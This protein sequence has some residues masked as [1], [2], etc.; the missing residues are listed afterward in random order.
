MNLV[1]RIVAA[2]N[3]AAGLERA[4]AREILRRVETKGFR[5][6]G[7]QSSTNRRT[8][9]QSL[10][11]PDSSG[12]HADRIQLIREAR[13]LEENSAVIKSILRKYRTFAVGRLQYI[14]RTK[15]EAV[16]KQINDYV[17]RWM[18]HADLCKK[19]HF[20]TLAGLGVTSMKRDGDVGF[21]VTEVEPTEMEQALKICPIR[22]QAIEADRIGSAIGYA[23]PATGKPF[24]KLAKGE[25]DFSGVVVDSLGRPKRY[26]V[27]NRATT[28]STMVPALEVAAE[29]FIHLYDPTRLD[30]YRG[31]S[32][33]DAAIND[34]K[35]AQEI[36]ACEKISVKYLSSVSGVVKNAAGEPEG[37]VVLDDSHDDYNANAASLKAVRPGEIKYLQE[38]QDFSALNFDRPTPTFNGFLET[39]MRWTGLTVNLPFGFI[40]SWAGQGTAVRMEAAQAAREFEQTQL[41]LE[42]RFLDPIIQRVIARGIQLGHI[43]PVPD[44]DSGEWRYPARVTADVGRESKALI[45]ENMSGLI[46]KTQIAAERGEDRGLVRS[47]LLAEQLEIVED[48]KRIVEASGGEIDLA[49]AIFML[50]KRQPNAPQ[51]P[52]EPAEP[53]DDPEDPADD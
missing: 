9:D 18:R 51:R 46:S 42:E 38:G 11:H 41:I 8:V 40:Y 37:D 4:R 1:D 3:P 6:E 24:R 35:D 7:A 34:I 12:D 2:I 39:L 15:N 13:W 48:A 22:L 5:R 36:L 43:N 44:F 16:N 21:I 47:F 33:F 19:H 10:S 14:A 53:A 26:R 45:E 17:N 50:E 52:P 29:N 27:Y 31:F 25:Q 49:T 28:G 32:A 23:G 20:R 30:G